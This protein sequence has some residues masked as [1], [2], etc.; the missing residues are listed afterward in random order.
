M[1]E[2][3][4][5]LTIVFCAVVSDLR[6]RRI[7]NSLC[8][9]G[10]CWGIFSAV[11]GT[12]TVSLIQSAAGILL[13]LVSL[14]V[15]YALRILGAGDIKLLSVIGAFTGFDVWKIICLSMIFGG[16]AGVVMVVR[17]LSRCVKAEG[18]KLAVFL[19]GGLTRISFSVP[20][21][22]GLAVYIFEEV[23]SGRV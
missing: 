9:Y 12:G 14:F 5:L 11:L 20:I 22:M 13:P 6:T 17:R 1:L 16:F 2:K 8:L 10:I 3:L 15:L 18:N 4:C 19:S 21:A 23:F 7:P